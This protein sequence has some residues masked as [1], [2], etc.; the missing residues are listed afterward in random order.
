[1]HSSEAD[2]TASSVHPAFRA[3]FLVFSAADAG[4]ATARQTTDDRTTAA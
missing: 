3:L 2:F 1:V 4:M